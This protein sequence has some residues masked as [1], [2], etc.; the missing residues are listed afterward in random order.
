MKKI[1]WL[2]IVGMIFCLNGCTQREQTATIDQPAEHSHSHWV[3]FSDL[4]EQTVIH[5]GLTNV[6]PDLKELVNGTFRGNDYLDWVQFE[7]VAEIREFEDP[8]SFE[9]FTETT[10]FYA[11]GSHMIVVCPNF[12]DIKD[13]GQQTYILIHELIHSLIGVGKNGAEETMNCFMEGIADYMANQV[14]FDTGLEYN[15]VYQNELYCISWL[16]ALYESE[17]ITKTICNGDILDFISEQT[18]DPDAGTNLHSSLAII[19][20]SKDHEAIKNAILTE[21]D[22][23]KKMSR[24]NTKVCEQFT[25]IFEKAY[26][27]YLN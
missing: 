19:D 14:L 3:K 15:L 4:K 8:N 6:L 13:S 2:L 17:N 21:M 25:N 10:A 7:S 1:T 9:A 26:A 12:F 20:K 23:L 24:S 16:M 5:D 18:G 27:P 22:I 11:A